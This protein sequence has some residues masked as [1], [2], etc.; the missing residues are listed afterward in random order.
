MT[1]PAFKTG[2]VAALF[3]LNTAAALAQQAPD[4]VLAAEILPGWAEA[5]GTRMVAVKIALANGWK[6]YW[7]T[8]GDAGIPPQFDFSASDNVASVEVHWPRPEVF[9]SAGVRAIGYHHEM[10]LPLKIT[11]KEAG[12][13]V[14]FVTAID[15]GIC[16][17]I[18][19]PVEVNVSAELDGNGA[20]DPV[21]SAALR[22]TPTPRNG[23]AH[24]VAEPI[25]DGMRVTARI[26]FD[27]TATEAGEIA[28]FELTNKPVWI[29][30]SV[31][32]REGGDLIS[33]AEFVPDAGKPFEIDLKSVRLTVLSGGEAFEVMGCDG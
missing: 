5:D 25:A 21:I 14:Y 16:K 17:E 30:E 8:P 33:T 22:A 6:T 20:A 26:T 10:I 18:C 12:D 3:A 19:V 23:I 9:E 2:A 32:H 7:R 15:M 31:S 13:E 28:L 4:G 29:S 11:P 24:C 1:H 27:A